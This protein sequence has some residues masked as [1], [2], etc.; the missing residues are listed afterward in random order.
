MA[1]INGEK[2]FLA[3]ELENDLRTKVRLYDKIRY[4]YNEYMRQELPNPEKITGVI[5]YLAEKLGFDKER[6]SMALFIIEIVNGYPEE[7]Y[8]VEH[9][10]Y[11]SILSWVFNSRGAYTFA[12]M[13]VP[14]RAELYTMQHP[15]QSKQDIAGQLPRS[16]MNC[17]DCQFLGQY[18]IPND[19]SQP[20]HYDLYWCTGNVCPIVELIDDR[21][22]TLDLSIPYEQAFNNN[23]WHPKHEAYRRANA[24]GYDVPPLR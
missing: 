24:F 15:P 14:T 12:T 18:N 23:P 1:T 5:M 11:A 17:P 22:Y 20:G 16:E 4:Q 21:D 9:R 19:P 6:M 10:Y 13:F 7:A 3:S 2:Y 8:G